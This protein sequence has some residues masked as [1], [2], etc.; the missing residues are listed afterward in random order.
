MPLVVA[1]ASWTGLGVLLGQCS[2]FLH[3]N[4]LR[5]WGCSA[6]YCSVVG[7]CWAVGTVASLVEVVGSWEFG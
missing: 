6:G 1:V 2:C 3:S 7:R 5:R 4:S